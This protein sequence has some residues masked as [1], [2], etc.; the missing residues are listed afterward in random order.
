M[1]VHALK[2]ILFSDL[3]PAMEHFNK[4][5]GIEILFNIMHEK[6]EQNIT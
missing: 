2:Y 4:I 3:E 6:L 1:W 5:A